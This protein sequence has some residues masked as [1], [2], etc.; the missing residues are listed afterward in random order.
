MSNSA[1]HNSRYQL[2]VILNEVDLAYEAW[3][4][5]DENGDPTSY[6][7]FLAPLGTTLRKMI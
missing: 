4:T 2:T 7:R 1:N 3:D 6:E 5:L